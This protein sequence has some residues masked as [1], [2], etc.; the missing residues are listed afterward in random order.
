MHE[1]ELRPGDLCGGHRILRLLGGGGQACVYD[2][3]SPAG[4]RCAL[5]VL[6]SDEGAPSKRA[7]RI[8]REGEALA[9]IEH[10]NVVRFLAAGVDGERVWLR[11]ELVEGESLR[12]RL[13]RR[14]DP[15]PS[16]ESLVR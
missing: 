16:L 12:D 5:K 3:L 10:V 1:H 13:D 4:K 6:T 8:G 2:A 14:H 11:L 7:A 15:P 9:S